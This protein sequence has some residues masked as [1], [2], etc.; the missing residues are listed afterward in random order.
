MTGRIRRYLR[1]VAA[2]ARQLCSAAFWRAFWPA[3]RDYYRPA[4][5][6]GRLDDFAERMRAGR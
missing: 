6:A 1:D 2:G 5:I 3:F 4:A